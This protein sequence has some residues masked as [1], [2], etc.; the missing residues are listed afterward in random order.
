MPL[1]DFQMLANRLTK[2][3][4]HLSKWVRREQISCYRLYDAD[5]PEFPLAVDWYDGRLHVAEYQR[6][7]PLDE[8]EYRI[9]RAGVR[10]IL[11]EVLGVAPEE[12]Y[13]KARSRQKGEAQYEKQAARG[14]VFIVEEAGLKFK[15]NLSDYLDTGLFLDHRI[16]RGIVRDAS[17]GKSMLNLFAYTGSFSV[18]AAAGG[19]AKTTTLDMS[20]T[21]LGWAEENLVL[22]DFS[23]ADNCLIQADVT[24]WLQ[25][26]PDEMYDIIVLDPP[27]FSNSKRM[28]HVLDIQE[29]HPYLINRCLKRLHPDGVIY[30]STN[31]RKFKL[32][33]EKIYGGAIVRDISARTIPPDFRNDKIHYCFE[34]RYRS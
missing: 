28:R 21:Y 8:T 13:Y 12:I 5:I 16:T 19:A 25:E 10:Q 26:S 33:H 23:L 30:F 1:P 29:D 6:N 7:H 4:R 20:A 34:V 31:F 18:Y 22:N 17:P 2:M 24:S 3:Q 27:T 14:K 32:N 9:W 11:S 15:V